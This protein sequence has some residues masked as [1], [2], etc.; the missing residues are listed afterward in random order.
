M[1]NL[2]FK[3]YP[4]CRFNHSS[5]DAALEIACKY[6]VRP[7]QIEEVRVGVSNAGYV[8]NCE[9]IEVKRK[10][11]NPVD[12]QFSIPYDV[13]CALVRKRANL[14]DFSEEL[15]KEPVVLE[16]ASR[17]Y[18]FID[19]EIE[20]EAGRGIAPSRVE[21]RTNTGG[22]YS[23]KVNIP[24]GH[25]SNTMTDEELET[26][27]KSCASWVSKGMSS[28]VVNDLIEMLSNLEQVDDIR[29]VTKLFHRQE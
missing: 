5:I 19:P 3:P 26:K 14:V 1:T 7:E 6:D 16:V 8:N 20:K 9:P 29:Q 10:P 24:K 22:V 28:E 25:P 18:P 2:S 15:I 27:F 23:A 12:A 4:C 17:V 13:A 21:V 11:R